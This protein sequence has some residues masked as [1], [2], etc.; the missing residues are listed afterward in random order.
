MKNELIQALQERSSKFKRAKELADGV[1]IR[2]EK[3]ITP[4]LIHS[5]SFM[6]TSRVLLDAIQSSLTS[7]QLSKLRYQAVSEQNLHRALKSGSGIV[8][9]ELS[10]TT[11]Q[12]A[13]QSIHKIS[14]YAAKRAIF[15]WVRRPDFISGFPSEY[16]VITSVKLSDPIP[17]EQFTTINKQPQW[18]EEL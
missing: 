13:E 16:D 7:E 2:G 3:K 15:I 4:C 9:V 14:Q 17:F 11:K 5:A 1:I 10:A 12:E 18:S 8:L 6:Q